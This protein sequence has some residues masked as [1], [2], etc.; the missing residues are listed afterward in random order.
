MIYNSI[1]ELPKR[2]KSAIVKAANIIVE[3]NI[4][5]LLQIV[6]FGSCARL[7][8]HVGSDVDLLIVTEEVINDRR[9]LSYIRADLEF[10]PD[11]MKGDI[12]FS[13]KDNFEASEEKLYMDIRRDGIILWDGGKYTDEY[14]QLLPTSKE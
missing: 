13:S 10:L 5:G 9:L 2:Y 4:S 6:L 14:Q 7:H 8:L 12:V 3:R 1:S 11:D